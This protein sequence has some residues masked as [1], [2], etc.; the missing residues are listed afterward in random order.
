MFLMLESCHFKSTL[1]LTQLNLIN[2]PKKV[3]DTTL[4]QVKSTNYKK[5]S[6]LLNIKTMSK[7]R[8]NR[9][10]KCLFINANS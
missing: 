8:L 2:K 1:L 9:R 10:Q 3:Q 6:F 7:E 5:R 4:T